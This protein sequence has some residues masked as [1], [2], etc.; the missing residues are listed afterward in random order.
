M[1]VAMVMDWLFSVNSM[2]FSEHKLGILMVPD[3]LKRWVM[4]MMLSVWLHFKHKMARSHR[5]IFWE[6]NA[7]IL[8]KASTRFMPPIFVE[9]VKIV[10]PV[11]VELILIMIVSIHFNVVVH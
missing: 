6:E 1:K 8:I 7:G 10:T 11:Q 3:F 5:D 4:Y 9:S 2:L